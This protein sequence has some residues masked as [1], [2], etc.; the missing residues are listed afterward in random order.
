MG[1]KR[2]HRS[3][4]GEERKGP[5]CDAAQSRGTAIVL[6]DKGDGTPDPREKVSRKDDRVRKYR[7]E[8]TRKKGRKTDS[9]GPPMGMLADHHGRVVQGDL[10]PFE[11]TPA[12]T[13]Q[14]VL[15]GLPTQGLDPAD[16]PPL[17]AVVTLEC[18]DMLKHL[19]IF[20]WVGGHFC[21][22]LMGTPAASKTSWTPGV[23]TT[24]ACELEHSLDL[25]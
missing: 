9:Q 4:A 24:T 17:S 21:L 14:G 11:H 19:S 8:S 18:L 15:D 5:N 20:G 1:G 12:I 7:E 6:V 16:L 23:G 2:P 22:S 13:G 25:L 3:R 10:H